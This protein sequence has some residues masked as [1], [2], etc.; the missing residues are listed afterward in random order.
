MDQ[1]H[2]TPLDLLRLPPSPAL[3][4]VVPFAQPAAPDEELAGC[5]SARLLITAATREHLELLARR[6][7]RAG[8]AAAPFVHVSAGDF[9]GEASAL[10]AMC[11]SLLDRARGGSLFVT[12]VEEMPVL[13]QETVL[14][15]LDE[16]QAGR[17]PADATRLISGTKVALLDR[18]RAG[19]F[20]EKLFYRL[21][22]LHVRVQPPRPLLLPTA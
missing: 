21:N 1:M 8:R 14:E 2:S 19:T 3:H 13:A 17:A 20:S 22:L 6:I 11:V 18:V 7:H 5:S 9:P 16:L 10:R 15:V 4:A 12:E